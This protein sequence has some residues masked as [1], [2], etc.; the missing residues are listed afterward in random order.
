MSSSLTYTDYFRKTTNDINALIHE[1]MSITPLPL[2]INPI[3]TKFYNS[4]K[5]TVGSIV[6]AINDKNK[7][8]EYLEPYIRKINSYLNLDVE[9]FKE[10]NNWQIDQDYFDTIL[11]GGY[12][13][14]NLKIQPL[15][16]VSNSNFGFDIYISTRGGHGEE[17]N[18]DMPGLSDSWLNLRTASKEAVNLMLDSIIEKLENSPLLEK[19]FNNRL[20]AHLNNFHFNAVIGSEHVTETDLNNYLDVLEETYSR[21]TNT[22]NDVLRMPVIQNNTIIGQSTIINSTTKEYIVNAIINLKHV[23]KNSEIRLP[24]IPNEKLDIVLPTILEF[25]SKSL[26]VDPTLNNTVE[27]TNERHSLTIDS[28]KTIDANTIIYKHTNIGE[29]LSLVSAFN[30]FLSTNYI[31]NYT[32]IGKPNRVDNTEIQCIPVDEISRTE[33]ELVFKINP[34][35]VWKTNALN[36]TVSGIKFG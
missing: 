20:Q 33:T 13:I 26:L 27:Q 16:V 19:L 28:F 4:P 15:T 9:F 25:G 30:G 17:Y 1:L 5:Y 14:P 21:R 18:N 12:L 24:F 2:W 34:Y 29:P 7:I 22:T 36:I 8:I 31:V 35:Y 32:A 11:Y 23:D 10:K 6:I 3:N